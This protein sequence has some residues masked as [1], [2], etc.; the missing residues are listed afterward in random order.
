MSTPH[1]AWLALFL[2][3]SL[4]FAFIFEKR[5]KIIIFSGFLLGILFMILSTQSPSESIDWDKNVFEI[6]IT[7]L[8]LWTMVIGM[9]FVNVR[10]KQ[11]CRVTKSKS[12]RKRRK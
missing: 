8:L 7:T 11:V 9:I 1:P 12:V 10:K 5:K 2:I 6:V 3:T 4:I